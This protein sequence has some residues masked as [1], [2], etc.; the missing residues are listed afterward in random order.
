MAARKN[1]TTAPVVTP[2]DVTH[3]LAKAK[4][5]TCGAA[6]DV[7][8][9]TYGDEVA[10]RFASKGCRRL[11]RHEVTEAKGHKADKPRGLMT[12]AE[13]ARAATRV[14][15]P[16]KAAR[17][18]VA[19]KVVTVG[20]TKFRVFENGKVEP[21]VA[22]PTESAPVAQPKAAKPR[23]RTLRPVPAE[24]QVAAPR[25]VTRSPRTKSDPTARAARV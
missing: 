20:G 5:A 17:P 19:S 25:K 1:R 24:R 18:K 22:E 4:P 13:R 11:P 23:V 15:K 16:G 14:T 7:L 8:V 9:T 10:D 3:T 21:I 12:K 2:L 6:H